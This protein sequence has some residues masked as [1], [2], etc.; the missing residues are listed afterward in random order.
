MWAQPLPISGTVAGSIPSGQGSFA[1]DGVERLFMVM[2]GTG[3][4]GFVLSLSWLMLDGS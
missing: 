3:A 1:M 2:I 4:S